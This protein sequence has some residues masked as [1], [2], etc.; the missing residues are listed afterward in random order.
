VDHFEEIQFRRMDVEGSEF[1]FVFFIK[2]NTPESLMSFS[3]I[4]EN[5][6]EEPRIS[7]VEQN[8]LIG[9]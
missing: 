7:I 3:N 8:N 2:T 9:G 5:T 1:Q 6:F 4:L